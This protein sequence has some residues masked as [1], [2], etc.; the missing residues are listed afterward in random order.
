MCRLSGGAQKVL[1]FALFFLALQSLFGQVHR[2]HPSIPFLES[3]GKRAIK[4]GERIDLPIE[5]KNV[6]GVAIVNIC[7]LYTFFDGSEFEADG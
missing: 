7:S 6:E 5:W 4:I 1:R 2:L 3:R